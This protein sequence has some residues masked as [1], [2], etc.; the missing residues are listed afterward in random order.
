MA[1]ET[2]TPTPA[3]TPKPEFVRR[4]DFRS[5]YSNNVQFEPFPAD[6]NIIFGE[7]RVEKGKQIIEQH[8]AVRVTWTQA[9]LLAYFINVQVA[10]CERE[11][12]KISIPKAML[13]TIAKLPEALAANPTAQAI[14]E[15]INKMR[16]EFIAGLAV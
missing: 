15:L 16:E 8:T 4:E 10:A 3:A 13:P 12:G 7:Q 5:V 6:L 1:E 9:K 2:G 14:F 11:H